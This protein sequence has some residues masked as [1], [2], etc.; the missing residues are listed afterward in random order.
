MRLSDVCKEITDLAPFDKGWSYLLK[1][2]K[3]IKYLILAMPFHET[4]IESVINSQLFKFQG[5]KEFLLEFEENI[6]DMMKL[7]DPLV[8]QEELT[9]TGITTYM[10]R[11]DNNEQKNLEE[12]IKYMFKPEVRVNIMKLKQRCL[13]YMRKIYKIYEIVFFSKSKIIEFS[14]TLFSEYC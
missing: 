6:L 9:A 12:M 10:P 2:K 1:D 14:K 11:D 13:Y 4:V 7:H 8:I 3:L 5:K